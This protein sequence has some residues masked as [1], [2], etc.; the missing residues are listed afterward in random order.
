M[1]SPEAPV[2]MPITVYR[3]TERA[4]TMQQTLEKT[5]NKDLLAECKALAERQGLETTVD[6]E[7]TPTHL[8]AAGIVEAL[9]S[10]TFESDEERIA[11]IAQT[12]NRGLNVQMATRQIG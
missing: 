6:L 12:I 2:T 4:H 1:H 5:I 11:F 3:Y 9:R 7:Y 10:W 8:V